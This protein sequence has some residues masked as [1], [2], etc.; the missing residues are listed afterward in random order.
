MFRLIE[1]SSGHIQNIV[2]V[3]NVHSLTVPV[4]CLYLA[5]CWLNEP[6]HVA[7]FLI[8]NTNICLFIYWL[9]YYRSVFDYH[10]SWWMRSEKSKLT[11]YSY[12]CS[13]RLR[14]WWFSYSQ[15]AL[16]AA[17]QLVHLHCIPLVHICI[18]IIINCC[19]FFCKWPHHFMGVG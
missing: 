7:E 12:L 2:L 3:H 13:E 18:C 10:S 11:L 6:K 17:L 15:V 1:P 16:T 14:D 9:N 5:W 8:L 4:L 19:Y